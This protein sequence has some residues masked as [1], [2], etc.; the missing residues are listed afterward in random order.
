MSNILLYGHGGSAN[1][2]CEAIVRSTCKILPKKKSR[3]VLYSRNP[4]EDLAIGRDEG[5]AICQDD[6]QRSLLFFE[7]LTSHLWNKVLRNDVL[8]HYHQTKNLLK[9][10]D[11]NS[12]ALSIGGD[13]YCYDKLRQ[14]ILILN[15]QLRRRIKASVLW[16]CSIDSEIVDSRMINDLMGY[17]VITPRESITYQSLIEKGIT[18]R[19]ILYP[20]PAF[21]LDTT[22]LPAPEGFEEGNT[23]GINISPLIIIREGKKGAVLKNTISLITHVLAT[24][25]MKI[26]LIPHV[27]WAHSNDLDVLDV[28]HACF[29]DTGR[30]ILLDG[31]FNAMQLKG[32]ISRCRMLICAR[33]H[34]GIAAYSSHVPTLV[35]GY[36]VKARG[37][38]RDIFGDEK[39]LVLPVQNMTDATQLV[40]AFNV[41]SERENDLRQHLVKFMPTY[42]AKALLAAQEIDALT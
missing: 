17:D 13:N 37:I 26:A 4:H 39:D 10:T 8:L 28:L 38:A 34:A 6:Q 30:V 29:E 36:S 12:I 24:T 20:D 23:L 42:A 18:K 21:Q 15:K 32:F 2:G 35:I 33:T 31:N 16:G 27:T 14:Q 9:N 11:K 41:F 5:I 3:I 40:H 19:T 1:H 7:R 25:N 22:L